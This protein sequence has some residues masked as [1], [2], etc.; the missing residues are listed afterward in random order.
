[1]IVVY[2]RHSVYRDGEQVYLNRSFDASVGKNCRYGRPV[3][4]LVLDRET[5]YEVPSW[6]RSLVS[7]IL[8][9]EQE[10]LQVLCLPLGKAEKAAAAYSR[11]GRRAAV[12]EWYEDFDMY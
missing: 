7:H 8:H 5:A 2:Q 11:G 6:G 10:P 12:L 9:D 3:Y 1:M 4:A